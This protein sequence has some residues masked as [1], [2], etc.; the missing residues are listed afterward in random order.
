MTLLV[1]THGELVAARKPGQ[2]IAVVMTMGAL[3]EGH[4]ELMRQA[5][6]VVGA[7][8][9]VVVTDF[10]NPTQFGAGEDFDRYPRTLDADVALC[11]AAGVDV[12]YAPQVSE[13]YGV[14]SDRQIAM[15]AG[16]LGEILE[17]AARPGHFSGMLTVVAK[18]LHLTA[19]DFALFG[20]KDYQQLVLINEMVEQLK[21]DVTVLPVATVREDDGLAMSSRNRYLSDSERRAAAVIPRALLAACVDAELQG[22]HSAVRTGLDV[23]ATEPSIEVDYLVITDERLGPITSGA[24]RMLVAA[25]V[26]STRLLD[27]MPCTVREP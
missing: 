24:G 22:A 19:A 23:L 15:N 20:E 27:N 16:G 25:R 4:A 18:L 6:A 10:V 7:S 2:Q 1:G 11:A 8:G 14:E 17:G 9:A 21:F 13:I 12:V 3:H 26:G 5:R